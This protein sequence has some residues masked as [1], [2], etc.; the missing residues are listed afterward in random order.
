M[1]GQNHAP[2]ALYHPQYARQQAEYLDKN[3]PTTVQRSCE[4]QTASYRSNDKNVA[5]VRHIVQYINIQLRNS[6]FLYEIN[7]HESQRGTSTHTL[8]TCFRNVAEVYS[9]RV[10][11]HFGSRLTVCDVRYTILHTAELE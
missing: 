7:E 1:S 10:Y 4:D 8:K 3:T 11:T 5:T 6:G 2:A 9:T